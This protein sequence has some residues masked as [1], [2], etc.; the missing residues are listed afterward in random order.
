MV[1]AYRKTE[2]S[3]LFLNAAT[4]PARLPMLRTHPAVKR[5]WGELN[6]R[7]G[8][9]GVLPYPL[10]NRAVGEMRAARQIGSFKNR[11]KIHG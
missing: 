7:A 8:R 3:L 4:R 5:I 1:E 6:E 10:A 11:S 2:K 9:R